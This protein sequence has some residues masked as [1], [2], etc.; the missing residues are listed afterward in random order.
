MTMEVAMIRGGDSSI[1]IAFSMSKGEFV[2]VTKVVLSVRFNLLGSSMWIEEEVYDS[3][4]MSSFPP[5]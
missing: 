3:R 1:P 5:V 4:G 2:W